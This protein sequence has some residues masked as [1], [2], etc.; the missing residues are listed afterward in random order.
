MVTVQTV[1]VYDVT[2]VAWWADTDISQEHPASIFRIKFKFRLQ[3]YMGV[4]TPKVN[5][6]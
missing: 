3:D 6:L 2:G 4:R 5:S 1:A